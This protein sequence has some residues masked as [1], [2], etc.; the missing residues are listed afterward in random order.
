MTFTTES[1]KNGVTMQ[2]NSRR[3][4]VVD[5]D[6]I[7]RKLLKE[8]LTLHGYNADCVGNGEDAIKLIKTGHYDILIIDYMMPKID[9]IELTRRIRNLSLSLPIIGISGMCNEK[10]FLSAGANLFMNKPITLSE[11]K[12]ILEREFFI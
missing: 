2:I 1:G 7:V 6:I 10:D 3:V 11:L 9:G 4:L 5:D 12:N 8:F